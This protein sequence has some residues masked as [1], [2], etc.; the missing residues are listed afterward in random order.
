M[1]R[2][3]IRISLELLPLQLELQLFL[4]LMPRI[5]PLRSSFLL[6]C[7]VQQVLMWVVIEGSSQ[8]LG[9]PLDYL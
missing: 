8:L 1:P 6:M 4:L 2:R 9:A 5:P 7:T 3:V